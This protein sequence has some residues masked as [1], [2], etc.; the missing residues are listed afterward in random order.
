MKHNNLASDDER[1][2]VARKLREYASWDDGEDCLVDCSE[3]GK[4]V[5]NLL[6]CGD[7]EGECYKALADLI[8]PTC[9]RDALL[10]LAD[11]FDMGAKAALSREWS[12]PT[13]AIMG[14]ALAD[15]YAANA[16]RIRDALGR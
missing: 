8:E 2:R 16:R 14:H 5:L 4:S 7:T 15:E 11:E 9:N 3:W 10:A 12:D 1:R 6:G 13:L